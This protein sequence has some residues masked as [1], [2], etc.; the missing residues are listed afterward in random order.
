MAKAVVLLLLLPLYVGLCYCAV[1]RFVF[2]FANI[3]M[4]KRGSCLFYIN[5]DCLLDF[6]L[7]LV[8]C[9]SSTVRWVGLQRVIVAFPGH[10]HFFFN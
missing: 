3:S 6:M 10:T 2:S 7:L 1:L 9:V 8:F 4:G 5:I